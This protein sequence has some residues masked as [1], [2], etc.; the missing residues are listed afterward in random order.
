M[1]QQ[2]QNQQQEQQPRSALGIA[3]QKSKSMTAEDLARKA[4]LMYL[5]GESV[6]RRIP[7]WGKNN[8]SNVKR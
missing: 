2:Q 1:E 8:S 6:T 3:F 7:N 5:M 4:F